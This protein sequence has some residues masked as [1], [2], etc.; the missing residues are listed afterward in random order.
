[1]TDDVSRETAPSAPDAARGVFASDRLAL[2]ERYA[3]LLADRRGGAR[4]DRSPRG[5]PAVGAAP[6]ELRRARRAGP[7]GCHGVRHRLGRRAA[8]DGAGDRPAGPAGD[9]G[10][11][12]AA[13]HD[14]PRGGRSTSWVC[15]HVEVRARPRRGRCTAS[16]T[17][18]IVTSRA[19]APLERLLGWSMPLVDPTGRAAGDEG[20]AR[21]QEE[22]GRGRRG[23]APGG[24]APTRWSHVLGVGPCPSHRRPAPSGRGRTR[25]GSV[26]RSSA[27]ARRGRGRRDA[28][29]RGGSVTDGVAGPDSG[30]LGW[31][32][33]DL[34]ESPAPTVRRAGDVHGYP[35]VWH[36]PPS[37]VIHRRARLSTGRRPRTTWFHVKQR[38]PS[39]GPAREPQRV[40][41]AHGR[42]PRRRHATFD[43]DATPL[44]R[45]ARAQ[46]CSARH[47]ALIAPGAA[48]TRRPPG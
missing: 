24:A 16:A 36:G 3:E 2:A 11:A 38:C 7:A 18:D 22:I 35:P 28:G 13:A 47:G 42:G 43:D 1:M 33:R 19:V 12:A 40:H 4:A 23:P 6:A 15:D 41:G 9:A 20:I 37:V 30:E 46:P 21:V 39:R 45:A 48:A 31:P 5:A 14:V 25:A 32:G 10:G 29:E 26:G 44:A 17:F 27:C 34:H 8:R